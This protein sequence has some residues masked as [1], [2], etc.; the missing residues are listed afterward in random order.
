MLTIN[1]IPHTIG[2]KNKSTIAMKLRLFDTAEW[3]LPECIELLS[4]KERM[5]DAIYMDIIDYGKLN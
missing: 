2:T 1:F 4:F 3:E 5:E